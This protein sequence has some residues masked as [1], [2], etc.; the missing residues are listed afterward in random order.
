MVE[1][2]FLFRFCALAMNEELV[3][4]QNVTGKEEASSRCFSVVDSSGARIKIVCVIK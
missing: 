4:A 1:K 3:L 2:A